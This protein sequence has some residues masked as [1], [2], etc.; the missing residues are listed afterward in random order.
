[1][2]NLIRVVDLYKSYYD[3]LTELPVLKGVDLEVES[4]EILAIVGASGVGK[5]TLLHL[6]GGLDRPTRGQIFYENRDIF[7]FNDRR[8]DGFRNQ[9]IGFVFQFHH[10]LGE[11][12]AVENVAMAAWIAGENSEAGYVRAKDLLD[13]VGLEGRLAHY[14]SQLSGGERQRVA[15]ARAVINQPQAVL[16]DEPTGNLD[17]R[18]S[19]AVIDLL[20]DLNKQ[21]GQTLIVVTHNQAIARRADRHIILADGKVSDLAQIDSQ[22]S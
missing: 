17:R 5:S 10:L 15:I 13:Y 21:L 16:A 19:E 22:S 14:P 18:T 3:G 20:W 1:M 8:L 2:S 7:D 12:T 9:E 11:F 4:G 6:I